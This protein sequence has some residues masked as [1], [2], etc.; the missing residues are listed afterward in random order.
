LGTYQRDGKPF[1][2]PQTGLTLIYTEVPIG[3]AIAWLAGTLVEKGTKSAAL[4]ETKKYEN[5][6]DKL[7]KHYTDLIARVEAWKYYNG[8]IQ[9]SYPQTS[10]DIKH[11]AKFKKLYEFYLKGLRLAKAKVTKTNARVEI[12]DSQLKIW[13]DGMETLNSPPTVTA[14]ES[15]RIANEIFNQA[16][17][18]SGGTK[19]NPNLD[20][21]KP[22]QLPLGSSVAYSFCTVVF[23]TT[24][25]KIQ[26][27][28]ENCNSLIRSDKLRN[29][30]IAE[31]DASKNLQDN[32]GKFNTQRDIDVALV[33]SSDYYDLR[34]KEVRCEGC[35]AIRDALDSMG[36]R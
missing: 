36:V 20:E 16:F 1:I 7:N 3:L 19:D 24:S 26:T 31:L 28:W 11:L 21:P 32:E 8:K 13:L 5:L 15:S 12:V 33:R 17:L 23:V 9:S 22:V 10:E 30:I 4:I 25:D 6:E 34:L 18:Y 2:D 14:L 29:S 27:L 35:K